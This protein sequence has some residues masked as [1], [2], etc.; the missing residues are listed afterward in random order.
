MAVLTSYTTGEDTAYTAGIAPY[1]NIAQTF[2]LSTDATLTS[3]KFLIYRVGSPGLCSFVLDNTSAGKPDPSSNIATTIFNGNV[4]TTDTAGEWKE[5]TI[6]SLDI[7]AGVYSVRLNST[8]SNASNKL[9]WK[10]DSTSASYTGGAA[11]W[12]ASPLDDPTEF[13]DQDF[14]FE[15]NGDEAYVFSPPVDIITYK[16]LVAAASNALFYETI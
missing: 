15:I 10:I 14:L 3:Y 1:W 5:F 12:Y 8:L 6:P 13:T 2:T 11:Y 16:R 9:M 4:I 7:D